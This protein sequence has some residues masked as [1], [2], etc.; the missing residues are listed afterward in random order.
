M[1]STNQRTN[2]W[3]GFGNRTGAGAG[4]RACPVGAAHLHV[5][6]VW[7]GVVRCGPGI[8]ALTRHSTTR[9]TRHGANHGSCRMHRVDPAFCVAQA[10]ARGLEV[11]V[12]VRR[13]ERVE[14]GSRDMETSV[15]VIILAGEAYGDAIILSWV[16][17]LGREAAIWTGARVE[18]KSKPGISSQR[19]TKTSSRRI[20]PWLCANCSAICPWPQSQMP[21]VLWAGTRDS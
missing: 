15:W 6:Q 20:L 14:T 18:T 12:R 8:N 13:G 19:R 2:D 21:N 16:G 4:A 3:G 10:Q 1:E 7:C 17:W 9:P 11:G 5:N